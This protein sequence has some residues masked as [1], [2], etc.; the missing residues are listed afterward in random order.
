MYPLCFCEDVIQV[1]TELL[2][3][4]KRFSALIIINFI[5]ASWLYHFLD[6]GIVTI[7][8][9]VCREQVL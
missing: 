6:Q 4:E 9:K 5:T 2:F 8:G 3:T 1:R 7:T